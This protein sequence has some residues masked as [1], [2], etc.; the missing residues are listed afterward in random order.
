MQHVERGGRL[1]TME[2]ARPRGAHLAA[3]ERQTQV[4][5]ALLEPGSE[6]AQ[7]GRVGRLVKLRGDGVAC[8]SEQLEA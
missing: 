4:R 6:V 2:Q 8:Q 5:D 3:T 1:A 7:A